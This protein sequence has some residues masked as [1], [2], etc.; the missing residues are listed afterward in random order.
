MMMM[1]MLK[2][3]KKKKKKKEFGRE[4]SIMDEESYRFQSFVQNLKNADQR[5][6]QELSVGGNTVHGITKFSDLSR[7][8]FES[9]YLT[10]DP[11][12]RSKERKLDTTVRAVD[13]AATLVD[14]TGVYT[15]PVNDQVCHL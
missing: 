3:K 8:E 1:M 10:A 6:A 14:W 9:R 7:A 11:S 15:T 4:Y 5:T 13:T 12:M 2:K